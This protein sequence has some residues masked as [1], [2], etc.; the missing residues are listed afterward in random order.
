[1][2][3]NKTLW[4]LLFVIMLLLVVINYDTIKHTVFGYGDENMSIYDAFK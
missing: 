1:M 4:F 2:L 3:D